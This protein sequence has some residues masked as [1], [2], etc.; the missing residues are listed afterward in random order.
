MT[1]KQ[2]L[3]RWKK[4]MSLTGVS[5]PVIGSAFFLDLKDGKFGSYT[6]EFLT[7]TGTVRLEGRLDDAAPWETLLQV[8]G[9]SAN[10]NKSLTP[11]VRV[12]VTAAT[13]LDID[14]NVME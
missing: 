10:T 12:N 4:I 13:A 14:V 1:L 5:A 9:N 2:S 6:F 8:A 7:G 3:R 11:Q